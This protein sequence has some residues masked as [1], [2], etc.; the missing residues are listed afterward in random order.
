MCSRRLKRAKML[1]RNTRCI[2]TST[3]SPSQ[4]PERPPEEEAPAALKAV[5]PSREGTAG[6]SDLE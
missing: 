3:P 1:E 4:S 2:W 5:G 6:P